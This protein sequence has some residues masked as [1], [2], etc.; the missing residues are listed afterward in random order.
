M[1]GSIKDMVIDGTNY[2]VATTDGHIYSGPIDNSAAGTAKWDFVST[3]DVTLGWVKDRLMASVN[4]AVY[5]LAGTGPALPTPLYT[6]P[7]AGWR[8]S[9]W[10]ELPAA[11]VAAGQ[12]GTYSA[13]FAFTIADNGTG[14]PELQPGVVASTMPTGE[15]VNCML[16]YTDNRVIFGTSVGLRVGEFS[17]FYGTLSYGPL[18]FPSRLE[19][20]VAVTSLRGRGSF[21]YAGTKIDGEASLLRVDLGT[22]TDQGVY[23]WAPDLRTPAGNTGTVN[24]IAVD[25][26]LRLRFAVQGYGVVGETTGSGARDAWLRTGRIRFNTVEGKHFKYA[27]VRTEG[28]GTVTVFATS[29]TQPEKQVFTFD[30]SDE[31]Q[32]FALIA[33]PA[34]WVQLTFH[35]ASGDATITSY[36]VQAL[37]AGARSRLITLP[38]QIFDRERNRH[39]ITISSPGRAKTILDALEAYEQNGDELT[40]QVPCLGID[41][42]RVTV[43]KFSFMQTSNPSA[44]KKVDVGGYGTLVFRTT[45]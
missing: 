18:T 7:N 33:G 22:Q 11:I 27:R 37:P 19:D 23:A 17:S 42:T 12:A 31:S 16:F 24:S 4:N 32:R 6:H 45:S 30:A 28:T 26:S 38:V 36:H 1:A 15:T 21:I 40:L 39:G 35:I 34:E 44:N 25:S 13:I 5:E 9:C 2:W 43:E 3:S 8:W 20:S 10:S 29:D 14:V 41:A